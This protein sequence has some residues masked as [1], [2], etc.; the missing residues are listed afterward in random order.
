MKIKQFVIE[1]NEYTVKLIKRYTFRF[2]TI[3]FE[4]YPLT[5]EIIKWFDFSLLFVVVILDYSYVH[6]LY[7]W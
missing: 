6:I 3:Q 4:I 1:N 7:R 2:R 5:R